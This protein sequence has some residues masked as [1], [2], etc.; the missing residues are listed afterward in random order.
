MKLIAV[1]QRVDSDN[2]HQERRDAVD[3]AWTEFIVQAGFLPIYLSNHLASAQ[4]LMDTLPIEGIILTGG[5]SL[6]A[7]GGDAPERDELEFWLLEQAQ[8]RK[9]PVLGIC[10]GMQMIQVYVGIRLEKV[11]GHIQTHQEI[12][13]LGQN[14]QVNSYHSWGSKE[15][16]PELEIL[17]H[18]SD[19]VIKA[20][21]HVSLPWQ[22]IMW[23]PERIQP[24]RWQDLA[25]FQEVLGK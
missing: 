21:K 1:S 3:Q 7:C 13:Y 11:E 17:G 6:I 24:F 22:G 25:L 5:N 8:K 4:I 15:N 9:M 23:H 12:N 16:N 2:A 14:I 18:A 10:R 20:I 19:G